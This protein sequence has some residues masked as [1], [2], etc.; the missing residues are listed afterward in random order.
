[1]NMK[2][3]SYL[4]VNMKTQLSM[5]MIKKNLLVSLYVLTERQASEKSKGIER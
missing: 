2:Q 1:M 3:I 4:G 5:K